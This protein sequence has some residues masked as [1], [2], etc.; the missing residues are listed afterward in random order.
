MKTK[1]AVTKKPSRFPSKKAL[2]DVS[3][4][5][6]LANKRHAVSHS[7]NMMSIIKAE[8]RKQNYISSLKAEYDLIAKGLAEIVEHE[9]FLR[10]QLTKDGVTHQ[11]MQDILQQKETDRPTFCLVSFDI[12]EDVRFIRDWLRGFLKAAGFT[13]QQRSVWCS[14]KDVTIQLNALFTHL[15]IDEWVNVH[16]TTQE[17]SETGTSTRIPTASPAYF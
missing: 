9:T 17:K 8:A 14:Q 5:L 13:K 3:E 12:P 6:E 15:K 11:L 16:V 1:N 2:Q 4:K 7:S 10:L